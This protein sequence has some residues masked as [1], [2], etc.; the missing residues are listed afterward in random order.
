MQ[1]LSSGHSLGDH[2]YTCSVHLMKNIIIGELK[3][4]CPPHV[5]VTIR[6]RGWIADRRHQGNAQLAARNTIFRFSRYGG[7]NVI[8]Y[9]VYKYRTIAV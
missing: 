7:K 6:R 2:L 3:L 5:Q 8:F 9:F 1:E 4:M